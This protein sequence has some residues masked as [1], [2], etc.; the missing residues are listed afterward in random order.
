ME[1][2]RVPDGGDY[3]MRVAVRS[4]FEALLG[5]GEWPEHIWSGWGCTEE[6]KDR[7]LQAWSS[8]AVAAAKAEAAAGT[9]ASDLRES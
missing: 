3:P 5:V 4:A 8:R 1:R 2:D 6:D 7:I 9:V